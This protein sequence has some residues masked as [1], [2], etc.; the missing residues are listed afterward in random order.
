M[1][2]YFPYLP[3][4]HLKD[5]LIKRRLIEGFSSEHKLLDFIWTLIN[6]HMDNFLAM[7][8]VMKYQIAYINC[9]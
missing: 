1:N 6:F 2:K 7:L 3:A 8:L 9:F 4:I 5:L